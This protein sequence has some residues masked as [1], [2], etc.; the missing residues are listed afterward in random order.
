MMKNEE[1]LKVYLEQI[2]N[3]GRNSETR[4]KELQRYIHYC[5]EEHN[6][7]VDYASVQGWLEVRRKVVNLAGLGLIQ[8][9]IHDFTEWA[10][11]LDKSIG[12]VPKSGRIRV[13]RRKPI[14]LNAEQIRNIIIGQRACLTKRS[15]NP[16]TYATITGLLFTTGIRISEAIGLKTSFV[17][18]EERSIYVPSGKT[19]QDR[20]I[21]ISIST[22][23]K[24]KEYVEWKDSF[25][26]NSDLF[27]I[28]NKVDVKWADRSYRK[29]YVKVVTELGYRDRA[30]VGRKRQNLRVHDLRHSFA[31][32]S[33]IKIYDEGVDVN[34]AIVQLSSI[35]GHK[36]LEYTYWYIEAIP[37][38]I[39][40]AFKRDL[41]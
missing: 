25:R 28:F 8:N 4:G 10:R 16:I 7:V 40:A 26:A 1:L 35:M 23:K 19:P 14:I 39:S 20:V 41:S 36:K 11:H 18:F 31:V 32:N 13:T 2:S 22:S 15:I 9:F 27:F 24:L 17:N 3:S 30:S 38:L 37:E 5:S 12:R 21:P 6:S 29:N 34:E 33:L